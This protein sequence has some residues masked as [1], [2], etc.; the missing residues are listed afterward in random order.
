[1]ILAWR[2]R[3][4]DRA[5]LA[6]GAAV[7]CAVGLISAAASIAIGRGKGRSWGTGGR[8]PSTAVRS[9]LGLLAV[10]LLVAVVLLAR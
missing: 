8:I 2:A 1:L 5:L 7:A 10:G 6:H 4:P 3:D 9:L